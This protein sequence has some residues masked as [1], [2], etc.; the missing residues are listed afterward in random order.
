MPCCSNNARRTPRWWPRVLCEFVRDWGCQ[1]VWCLPWIYKGYWVWRCFFS[2]S[3]SHIYC[4]LI[5][6]SQTIRTWFERTMSTGSSVLLLSNS[7]RD[8]A[9]SRLKGGWLDVSRRFASDWNSIKIQESQSTWRMPC[10]RLPQVRIRIPIHNTQVISRR[11]S[12]I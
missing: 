9:W 4:T 12:L 2:F 7:S 10:I 1:E 3:L 5:R 8:P 6:V 11:P